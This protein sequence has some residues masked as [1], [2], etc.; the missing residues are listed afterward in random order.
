MT[1]EQRRQN[2]ARRV[3]DLW[4]CRGVARRSNIHEGYS[5]SS[6]LAAAPNLQLRTRSLFERWVLCALSW[7]FIEAVVTTAAQARR[8]RRGLFGP[9]LPTEVHFRFQRVNELC[10]SHRA[11]LPQGHELGCHCSSHEVV[12]PNNQSVRVGE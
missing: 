8:R 12:P 4:R 9:F 5:L 10:V 6:R 3:A 1:E 11:V 7:Q 2:L